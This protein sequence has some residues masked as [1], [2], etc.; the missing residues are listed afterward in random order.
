[1][2]SGVMSDEVAVKPLRPTELI[3]RVERLLAK[4]KRRIMIVRHAC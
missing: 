1:M 2:G 4:G 3:E